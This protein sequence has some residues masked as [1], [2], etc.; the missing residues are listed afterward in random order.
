MYRPELLQQ[1]ARG[2]EFSKHLAVQLH[3]VDLPVIHISGAV[4]V[5]TVKVL[6]GSGR[7][8]DRPRRAYVRVLSLEI[9]VVVEH[10]DTLVTAVP[11]VY[12]ALGIG[13]DRVRRVELAGLFSPRSPRL[14]EA[15]I[16]VE[17]RHPRVAIPVGDE[18][19]ARG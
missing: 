6:M 10:L 5:R 18:N 13:G 19:I 2:T 4:G 15:A 14:Q 8:A 7:D 11:Y 16:L 9:A 1:F 3:L 12:V 17:L